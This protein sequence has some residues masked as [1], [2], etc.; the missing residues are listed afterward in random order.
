MVT[1]TTCATDD[2]YYMRTE[3]GDKIRFEKGQLNL[4][5]E[6]GTTNPA[7]VVGIVK[8]GYYYVEGDNLY[9]IM[10]HSPFTTG[11]EE[12]WSVLQA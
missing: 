9:K 3:K 10:G 8:D 4:K 5:T 6:K 7:D 12:I 1:K 2:G 11:G